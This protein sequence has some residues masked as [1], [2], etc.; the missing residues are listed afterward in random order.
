MCIPEAL[1]YEESP[2]SEQFLN[3]QNNFLKEWINKIIS[4]IFNCYLETFRTNNAIEG[5]PQTNQK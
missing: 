5:W 4:D 1:L 3:F 2:N